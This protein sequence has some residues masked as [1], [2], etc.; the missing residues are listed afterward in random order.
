MAEGLETVNW[1]VFA[2]TV[3]Q[4]A[5]MFGLLTRL[6]PFALLAVAGCAPLS[7]YYQPGVAVSRMQEDTTRCEVAALKDAPVATE[8]R[9]RPPVYFP[10]YPVC[11]GAGACTYMPGYWAPGGIYS[12]DLNADLRARV[13]DLCMAEKGYSP[14]TIERCPPGLDTAAPPGPTTTLPKLSAASCAIRLD[15]GGWRIVDRRG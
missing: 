14:V 4:S 3:R 7:I 11:N 10:G 15:D 9:Q 13:T 12:V 5:L 1:F 2:G 6:A 8:I